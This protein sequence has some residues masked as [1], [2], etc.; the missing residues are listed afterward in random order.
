[1]RIL[2]P[3]QETVTKEKESL[4]AAMR[5]A[6]HPGVLGENVSSHDLFVDPLSPIYHLQAPLL[7]YDG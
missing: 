7:C 6:K 5:A 4:L 2:N 1:M 3:V